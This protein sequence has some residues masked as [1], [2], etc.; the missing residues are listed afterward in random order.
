M[1][2]V[3]VSTSFTSHVQFIIIMIF[4]N[5]F[6]YFYEHHFILDYIT[7]S[8]VVFLVTD[9]LRIKNRFMK[10]FTLQKLIPICRVSGPFET[11]L[12]LRTGDWSLGVRN[13]C[14]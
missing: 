3:T 4:V 8:E 11:V 5:K 6:S 7:L 9:I 10:V 1:S 2:Y 14:F 13:P 12:Y